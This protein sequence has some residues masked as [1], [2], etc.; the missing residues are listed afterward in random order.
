MTCYNLIVQ[1]WNKAAFEAKSLA[2]VD[3]GAVM[4][5]GGAVASGRRASKIG[6]GGPGLGIGPGDGG[7]CPTIAA[8]RRRGT[9]NPH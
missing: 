4:P 2:E 6:T 5:S 3:L 7:A 8:K 9:Y 1:Q